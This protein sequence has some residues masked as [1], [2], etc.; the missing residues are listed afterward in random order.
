MLLIM[1]CYIVLYY[2]VYACMLCIGLFAG[3]SECLEGLAEP[4]LV[5]QQEAALPGEAEPDLFRMIYTLIG[6]LV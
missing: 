1:C 2:C 6:M 4:H 3:L 5:R